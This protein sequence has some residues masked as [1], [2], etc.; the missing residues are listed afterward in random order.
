MVPDASAA[1]TSNPAKTPRL[2]SEFKPHLVNTAHS[3]RA[4][5]HPK[6]KG[7]LSIGVK[8]NRQPQSS[9]LERGDQ[10][11]KPP[12]KPMDLPSLYDFLVYFLY[13][14]LDLPALCQI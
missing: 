4:L 9:I 5:S 10:E 14:L 13:S 3:A 1:S 8:A 11:L 7:D 12:S 6:L 2:L